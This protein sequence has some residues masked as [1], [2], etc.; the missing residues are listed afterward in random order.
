MHNK[1]DWFTSSY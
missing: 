1:T